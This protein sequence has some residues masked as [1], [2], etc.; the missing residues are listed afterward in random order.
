MYNSIYPVNINYHKPGSYRYNKGGEAPERS[1]EKDAKR[2]NT[3]PNGEKVSIDYTK[4]QINISQVVNDFKNT[5]VAINAPEDISDEVNLYLSLVERESHK[6]N[7]SKEI[8]LSNLKNAS[9]VSDAYIAR[10]LNKPSNVVE[11]WI[12]ALFLQRIN[13]NEGGLVWRKMKS[14]GS[15]SELIL[16]RQ[17]TTS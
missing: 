3:F 2:Q 16:W 10:S 14:A 5:I 12:D 7:P 17:K 8:I 4:G 6:E 13:L 11:G 1:V 15:L 9:R